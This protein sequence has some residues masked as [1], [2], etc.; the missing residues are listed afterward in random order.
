MFFERKAPVPLNVFK[1]HNRVG[2]ITLAWT[3]CY[4]LKLYCKY[5]FFYKKFAM[6]NVC[7]VNLWTV[8]FSVVLLIII[9]TLI[10]RN[11]QLAG[12]PANKKVVF[13]ITSYFIPFDHVKRFFV[14]YHTSLLSQLNHVLF[15]IISSLYLAIYPVFSITGSRFYR[16]PNFKKW[17]D[18]LAL[19]K[20][21]FFF[22]RQFFKHPFCKQHWQKLIL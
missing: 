6:H 18:Y 19:L 15:S 14:K 22:F 13:Q 4:F 12:Y 2:L 11:I 8:C 17:L 21:C 20:K 5:Y 16:I 7:C 9:D 3:F 10:F 1:S